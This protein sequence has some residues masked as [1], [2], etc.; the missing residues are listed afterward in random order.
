MLTIRPGQLEEFGEIRK[1]GFS[2]ALLGSIAEKYP[3][4]YAHLSEAGTRELME[5]L[6]ASALRLGLEREGHIALFV[7]LSIEYGERFQRSPQAKRV[8]RLLDHP[9]LPGAAKLQGVQ[10][11]LTE[12]A[13]GRRLRVVR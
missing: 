12:A 4:E 2:D 5:R 3:A 8:Q 9:T 6:I 1:R 10:S 13:G 7:E 11:I